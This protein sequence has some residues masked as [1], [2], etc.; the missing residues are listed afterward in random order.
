MVRRCCTTGG[1]Y[2]SGHLRIAWRL[3]ELC[4]L[5]FQNDP[6]AGKY[7]FIRP[8]IIPER[9]HRMESAD[10]HIEQGRVELRITADDDLQQERLFRY[11]KIFSGVVPCLVVRV[12]K[13]QMMIVFR[14]FQNLF[15]VCFQLSAGNRVPLCPAYGGIER[16]LNRHLTGLAREKSCKN[17]VCGVDFNFK[18]G[19]NS[20]GQ[21]NFATDG[22]SFAEFG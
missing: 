2:H 10:F 17:T 13:Q 4:L 20:F 16:K 3:T 15:A 12:G 1:E 7:G 5:L 21:F 8:E 9:Q 22:L 11:D 14:M 18:Q 6:A 19:I